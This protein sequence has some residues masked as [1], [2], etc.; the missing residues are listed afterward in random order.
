M[1]QK[2]FLYNVDQLVFTG[3][4][5][6]INTKEQQWDELVGQLKDKMMSGVDSFSL[7]HKAKYGTDEAITL[8]EYNKSKTS[9]FYFFNAFQV[10]AELNNNAKS[11]AQK[12]DLRTFP[13]VP[14]QSKPRK[15][16]N[17]THKE[18]YNLLAGRSVCKEFV[19]EKT[20]GTYDVW[21]AMDF[22]K[23][24]KNGDFEITKLY[25][26]KTYDFQFEKELAKY[27]IKDL[28]LEVSR[29]HLYDSLKRGNLQAVVM[30]IDGAEKL[31]HIEAD[32]R[33]KTFNVFDAQGNVLSNDQHRELQ[34]VVKNSI[35]T[36]KDFQTEEQKV[37]EGVAIEGKVKEQKETLYLDTEGQDKRKPTSRKTMKA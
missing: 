13:Q 22:N 27:P 24:N 29:E 2:N 33:N 9:D 16:R 3:F 23:T 26:G 28:E 21:M 15:N 36:R 10:I 12:F 8:L 19:N 7:Q 18:S 37:S 6:N 35:Y 20:G 30:V 32:A 5:P 25:P 14:G 11:L 17:I 4:G 34:N 31:Y 1:N